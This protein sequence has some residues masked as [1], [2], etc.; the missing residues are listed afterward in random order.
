[1]GMSGR[2]LEKDLDLEDVKRILFEEEGRVIKVAIRLNCSKKAIYDLLDEHPELQ[3]A[4]AKASHR[5]RDSTLEVAEGVLERII[6]LQ[7]ENI[8]LAAKQAQFILRNSKISPYNPDS[9]KDNSMDEIKNAISLTNSIR[10][11]LDD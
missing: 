9:N 11:A 10:Q 8:E 2:S 3:E 5:Y 6:R 1:M 4:R 7:D